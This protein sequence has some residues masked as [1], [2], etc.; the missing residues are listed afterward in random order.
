MPGISTVLDIG[1]WALFGNQ[2]AIETTGNN[3]ANAN[4]PGY[5]RRTVRFEEKP[6]IDYRPGQIGMGVEATEVI[7]HFDMFIEAQYHDMASM[8][9]RYDELWSD[10]KSV[11]SLFN[12][13]NEYGLNASMDQFFGYWQ[14][15][16]LRPDDYPSRESLISHTQNM[17]SMFNS[18]DADMQTM[19]NMAADA[20]AAEVD[21]INELIQSIAAINKQINS[22]DIPGVNNANQMLDERDRLVRELGTKIDLTVLDKGGA[23]SAAS[24]VMSVGDDWALVT[25]SG[26]TLVQGTEYFEIKYEGP[27][28]FSSLTS[29][30][31]FDGDIQFDGESA[32]EYTI[33]MLSDGSVSSGAGA[34]TFRVSLDGGQTW[35]KDADGNQRVFNA[36]PESMKVDVEGVEIWFDNATQPL[37]AG[38]E[39][40]VVPKNGVYWY[41]TTSDKENIT[42]QIRGDGTD[43]P[44]RLVGG[45]LTA[46]LNFADQYVGAYRDKLDAVSE[47]MIWEVNRLHSQGAGLSM[48]SDTIGSYSVSDPNL[49][50]GSD[51][52][53]LH[54]STRLESGNVSVYMFDADQNHTLSCA[55]CQMLDFDPV[56]PGIQNFDP[57]QHTLEDVRAAFDAID[58]LNASIEN[59]QLRLTTDDGY[60]VGFGADTSGLLAGLGINTFFSGTGVNDIGINSDILYDSKRLNA[61]HINGAGEYNSGDNGTAL[62][63]ANLKTK[64]VT[65]TSSFHAGSNQS[66]L[67]Y[68]S[69]IVSRVGAD[70]A[71]AEFSFNYYKSLSD[72]L[73][74]QQQAISGV[75]LDEEMSNLIKYQHSYRA[76]AKLITTADEMLQTIL[77]LK[78]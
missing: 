39:F 1:R 53:G 29:T 43:D 35:L 70:T 37:S 64:E 76:A 14:D 60:Q 15:L 18:M 58:H 9:E 67:E 12:E 41:R 48:I 40:T 22:H 71:G 44:M 16:S 72:D 8:R 54:W 63:I 23:N 69:G 24:N 47:A 36:R 59:N 21:E 50:L 77:G 68:Y 27:Q 10:L 75:N 28:T 3:V 61:G 78:Q 6:S 25:T 57:D 38:D 19:Q 49:A 42:P 11:D 13:S 52:S 26:K 31:T 30:S 55:S 33:Q 62:D 7:R 56:A 32:Y 17:I 20:A 34:A 65:I 45:K 74:M 4:T 51:S 66:I 73:E 2:A 5:T 46:L